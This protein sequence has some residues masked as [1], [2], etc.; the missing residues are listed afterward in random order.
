MNYTVLSRGLK[1][2]EQLYTRHML[3]INRL[4]ILIA[5]TDVLNENVHR[6]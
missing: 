1:H 5:K 4:I 6:L 3:D 2:Q